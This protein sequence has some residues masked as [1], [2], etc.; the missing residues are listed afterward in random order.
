MIAMSIYIALLLLVWPLAR[1][2]AGTLMK[3]IYALAPIA[4]LLYV[5]W[6]MVQRVRQSDEL[7]QRTHLIALGVAAAIVSIVSLVSGFLA[8]AKLLTLDA[9]SMVLLW[10]FPIIMVTYGGVR[11]YVSRRYGGGAC[12]DDGVPLRYRFLM[13]AALICVV[14]AYGYF[15]AHDEYFTGMASGMAAGL[16][17]GAVIVWF[18]HW[19]RQRQAVK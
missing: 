4:P 7:E 6:L 11:A 2:E 18:R 5:L 9:T 3:I 15:R 12:D 19:R 16:G 14:A 10:I 8:A 13:V 17:V 1:G